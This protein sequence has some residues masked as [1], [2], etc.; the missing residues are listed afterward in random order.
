MNNDTFKQ[1][2]QD[3]VDTHAYEYMREVSVDFDLSMDDEPHRAEIRCVD[4][5]CIE[6]RIPV[7]VNHEKLVIDI[8]D[9]GFLKA[10][11]GGFYA[12]LW[13][14]AAHRVYVGS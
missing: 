2:V 1:L 12:Y 5:R 11:G 3:F 8:G 9:A 6:W 4:Y 14:D 13:N 7:T 10:N